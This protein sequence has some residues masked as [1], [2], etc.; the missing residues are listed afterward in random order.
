MFRTTISL[1]AAVLLLA[2][3]AFAQAPNQAAIKAKKDACQAEANA[4]KLTEKAQRKAF[5]VECIKK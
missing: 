1:T 4:K 2:G 5:M 3:A